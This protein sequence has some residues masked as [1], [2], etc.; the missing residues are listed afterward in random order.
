M[1]GII[2][3]FKQVGLLFCVF[4]AVLSSSI[5]KAE[6]SVEDR[7]QGCALTNNS[8]AR[9]ACYDLLSGRD[10]KVTSKTVEIPS[11]PLKERDSNS[12]LPAKKMHAEPLTIANEPKAELENQLL[13][14]TKCTR[15]GG[16][17]KY[18]FYLDDGQVWK[19][20]SHNRMNFGD[21]NIQVSIHKDFFGH[22]MQV[23]G[24][25]KKFRISRVR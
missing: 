5:S 24:T 1:K 11:L 25:E 15:G 23:E 19:Q 12:A 18:T 20:V 17:D 2:S 8:V 6:E 21:C 9:L 13:R 4:I 16:N 7:L 10:N 3:F 14:I 22:K